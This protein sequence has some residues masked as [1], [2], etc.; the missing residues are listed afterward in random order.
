MKFIYFIYNFERIITFDCDVLRRW[1]FNR[2]KADTLSFSICNCFVE[3]WPQEGPSIDVLLQPKVAHYYKSLQLL[4]G[5]PA[6]LTLSRNAAWR[7]VTL[8]KCNC[9]SPPTS[10]PDKRILKMNATEW[11]E[12]I[13]RGPDFWRDLKVI[14]IVDS[15]SP[16]FVTFR[17]AA[18]LEFLG[19][20]HVF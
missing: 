20:F 2:W 7:G 1:F 4:S 17:N 5:R 14:Q 8:H 18:L 12:S 9:M 11:A 19:T 15:K 3:F 6:G 10:T 16:K 13:P